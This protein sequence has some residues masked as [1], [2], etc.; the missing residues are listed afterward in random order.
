MILWVRANRIERAVMEASGGYE[1]SWAEVLRTA[2]VEI[3][4]VDP[5]RIRH[6]AK[7][8][9][10]L[11]KNDRI[12]AEVIAWF[13]ETFPVVGAEPHERAREEVDRLVQARTALKDLE[14]RIKQQGEHQPP[15]LVVKALRA[16][17]KATRAERR[18]LDAAIA[19]KIK[20]NPGLRTPRRNHRQRAGACRPDGRRRDRLGARARTHQQRGRSRARRRR[21]I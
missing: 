18:K 10:R 17:A 3:V 11:A 13:A 14:E 12:D 5:K 6:F 15:P 21:A 2:G 1:R 4:I 8:A 19:A 7:A 9:G 16:L 20:A